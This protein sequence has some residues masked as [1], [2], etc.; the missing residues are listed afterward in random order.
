MAK[1]ATAEQ[2]S[3]AGFLFEDKVNAY[4]LAKMLS[5]TFAI[6]PDLGLVEKVEYQVR[7]LGWLF[8]DFLITLKKDKTQHK[9]AVSSKSNRQIT[10]SG[11]P[12]DV[13]RDM[14]DQF[15]GVNQD[16]FDQQSDYILFIVAPLASSVMENLSKLLNT[17][18]V[19]DPA[20][21]VQRLSTAN[22]SEPQRRLFRSFTCPKIFSTA[23]NISDED[24]CRLLKRVMVKE[25]DFRANDSS[26]LLNIVETGQGCL[27]S[28]DPQE[29]LMLFEKLCGL[30]SEYAQYSGLVNYPVLVAEL[31]GQFEL[32]GF[33][34]H[35]ADWQK[36]KDLT[37]RK[38]ANIP[39]QLG[40]SY[41]LDRS[42]ELDSLRGKF[43]DQPVLFLTGTSGSGKSVLAKSFLH[44]TIHSDRK[45]IWIDPEILQS[46]QLDNYFGI[47]HSLSE[48]VCK[49]QSDGNLLVV[50]G[51]D[52]LY[53]SE[54]F[55]PLVSLVRDVVSSNSWFVLITCQQDDYEDLIKKFYRKNLV[56]PKSDIFSISPVTRIEM[57][58]V[59]VHFPAMADLI[60]HDHLVK[61]LSNLKFLDIV[62]F[63]IG[64][65]RE[66]QFP[67]GIGETNLI[68]WV[69][70]QEI[71]DIGDNGAADGRF[72][73]HLAEIQANELTLFTPT[74]RFG[75]SE[76]SPLTLLKRNK[77][78]GEQDDRLFFIHDLFGD[79]SRY[80]ILRGNRDKILT[81]LPE[82]DLFSPLWCKAIRLFGIY[83][84]EKDKGIIEWLKLYRGF[85]IDNPK[86]KLLQNLLLESIIYANDTEKY[87]GDLWDEFLKDDAKILDAFFEQFFFK[88]TI[89]NPA[90]LKLE[91]TVGGATIS[92]LSTFHRIPKFSYWLP[93]L[94]FIKG[95]LEEMPE[96]ARR[97]TI[98]VSEMWLENTAKGS[99]FRDLAAQIAF[100]NAN[101]LADFKLDGGF[102]MGHS[103]TAFYKPMLL[104]VGEMPT[105]I[106][107]LSLELCRRTVTK[108]QLEKERKRYTG[109]MS[110][111][112]PSRGTKFPDGPKASV[113]DDFASA[114]LEGRNFLP[115]IM[116][117]PAIAK[118][119]LLAIMVEPPYSP[120]DIDRHDYKYDISDIREWYPPFYNRGPFLAFL[121]TAPEEALDLIISLVNYA[122]A[123]WKSH[124]QHLK[125]DIHFVTLNIPSK[126]ER[127]F[128]GDDRVYFWFRDIGNAPDSLV[129]VLMALE[130]FLLDCLDSE[131]DITRFIKSILEKSDSLAFLGLLSSVGRYSPK[132]FLSELK[133]LLYIFDFYEW[134]N[135][136]DYGAHSIEGMQ[137]TG[138]MFFD[139]TT[140]KMAQLWHGL[141]HRRQSL[142]MAVL[143]IL[144]SN[145]L[146]KSLFKE[147]I[148]PSW[149]TYNDKLAEQ[150]Y[151]HPLLDNIIAQLNADNYL[152]YNDEQYVGLIYK[153][154]EDLSVKLSEVRSETSDDSDNFLFSF[155]KEQEL[156]EDV[157]Y[158]LADMEGIWEKVQSF[159]ALPEGDLF[160]HLNQRLANI[161]SGIAVLVVNE[162]LWKT[163]HPEYMPWIRK[164]LEEV[165]S[166][167]RFSMRNIGKFST[168]GGWH[169]FG[170]I[171]LS[172]LYRENYEDKLFRRLIARF[173]LHST[174]HENEEFYVELLNCVPIND[175]RY[176]QLLNLYVARSAI[177]NGQD[178]SPW[179]NEVDWETVFSTAQISFETNKMSPDRVDLASYRPKHNIGTEK[180]P[181][182]V[183]WNKK[184]LAQFT[185]CGLDLSSLHQAFQFP[186][187]ASITDAEEREYVIF[188]Y[189]SLI[190]ALTFTWGEVSE[191]ASV[192]DIELRSF[193]HWMI[194]RLSHLLPLLEADV[195]EELW[196][197]ILTYGNLA[198][199]WIVH[200]FNQLLANNYSTPENYAAL[201]KLWNKMIDFANQAE[202]WKFRKEFFREYSNLW[203]TL[204]GFSDTGLSIWETGHSDLLVTVKD[205]LIEWL[206][207]RYTDGAKMS[208]LARILKSSSAGLF[209]KVGV[210]LL[211]LCLKYQFFID[212]REAPEGFKRVP[213]E[214][215]DSIANTASF[216]WVN[217]KT[218]IVKEETTFLAFKEIVIHLVAVQNP[219][220]LD[221]QDRL[222]E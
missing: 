187:W 34:A 157:S 3:G 40:G 63:H 143:S 117:D 137:M 92:Q 181:A 35:S 106:I 121:Q 155:K 76:L 78:I 8:D 67:N 180:R 209:L 11:F 215:Y 177:I 37:L 39:D 124:Q 128:Y 12:A 69:W 65:F 60:R 120:S 46:G 94:S 17:A 72:L 64:N 221:L 93:V 108:E 151:I 218:D 178:Q 36:I 130:K 183:H 68:D 27:L 166:K 123:N 132:L 202:T 80:K 9:V 182:R 4:F 82:K 168:S 42:A 179:N 51:A 95:H 125:Q 205:R 174:N 41:H 192:L 107:A 172:R 153:E 164:I 18:S 190:E 81:Y 23:Y 14:W 222:I 148:I 133:P 191:T 5:G 188:C 200:F 83:L 28:K 24:I 19:S 175:R 150:H 90:V 169:K 66:D 147:D 170:S 113:D 171:I 30:R 53:K 142:K 87:L 50:D 186:Q 101:Y 204:M 43:I 216:L 45:G 26:D 73:Q 199:K 206:L 38:I 110:S 56:I 211:D 70:Q 140:Y 189:K 163:Q 49:N 112:R 167:L 149:Q 75:I 98:K 196:K 103:G 1:V 160:Y 220:G 194:S 32:S 59:A 55:D 111:Y 47:R 131:T 136:L 129:S 141:P 102:T 201:G 44:Q 20:D 154:P 48:L 33:Y 219:I 184:D 173:V 134:E 15:L 13:V 212:N 161:F 152:P 118:E 114:C 57:I 145:P 84:L 58:K 96:V 198:G 159:Y 116:Q 71:L 138:G 203:E 6:N 21:M 127:I 195:A 61:L 52:R 91:G 139:Q 74:T 85:E 79:W 208:K 210:G 89:P 162:G 193:D 99:V 217:Y 144:L 122:T 214:Y 176:I 146:L 126:G 77:I 16:V 119:I 2:T 105:E 165:I 213:F 104:A 115:M 135:G 88:A 29:A 25:F 10:A 54:L 22:F 100:K 197:P 185:N 158:V 97:I 62:L 7:A 109:I 207:P 86:G 31:R 156:K